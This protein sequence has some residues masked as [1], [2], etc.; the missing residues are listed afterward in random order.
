MD[1]RYLEKAK[2][3]CRPAE[4]LASWC[5][6]RDLKETSFGF[7]KSVEMFPDSLV[8][9]VSSSEGRVVRGDSF[10]RN[11]RRVSASH[12]LPAPVCPQKGAVSSLVRMTICEI[13]FSLSVCPGGQKG[14][15]VNSSL[16]AVSPRRVGFKKGQ[17]TVMHEPS[18]KRDCP[19]E[20]SSAP[21]REVSV[22]RATGIALEPFR[23]IREIKGLLPSSSASA[24]LV[25]GSIRQCDRAKVSGEANNVFHV[26][27]NGLFPIMRVTKG[28][29][30]RVMKFYSY[31]DLSSVETTP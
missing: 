6:R 18:R 7:R 31:A 19:C 29:R 9:G 21:P 14:R 27:R 15:I 8:I 11:A 5:E 13:H 20:S 16:N 17:K 22:C 1:M 28:R 30:F 23:L 24:A 2:K 4:R 26:G 10:L 25:V 12:G 3:L